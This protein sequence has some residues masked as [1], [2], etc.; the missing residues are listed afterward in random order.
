M[1]GWK[2]FYYVH[3]DDNPFLEIKL[4]PNQW[5]FKETLNAGFTSTD[6]TQDTVKRE[7]RASC[8]KDGDQQM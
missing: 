3:L 8:G 7:P 1:A 5:Y 4:L 6:D 2:A